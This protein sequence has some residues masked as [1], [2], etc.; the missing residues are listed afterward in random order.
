MVIAIFF[1]LQGFY[2]IL[3]FS[4]LEMIVLGIGLFVASRR[5]HQC[6][7]IQVEKGCV[8]IEKGCF[9]AEQRWVFD[10]C[11]IRLRDELVYENGCQRKLALGAQDSY[12]EVGEFLTNIEKDELAFRLKDCIILA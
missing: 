11:W 8:A 5:A 7:I 10:R 4:G 2:F 6:Q 9:R 3:P 12:V 1:A